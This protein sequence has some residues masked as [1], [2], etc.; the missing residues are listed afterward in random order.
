MQLKFFSNNGCIFT[1][2]QIHRKTNAFEEKRGEKGEEKIS[3]SVCWT[4]RI[5]GR[6][7]EA[8]DGVL[9]WGISDTSP[10]HI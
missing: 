1:S 10:K 8:K 5:M 6:Y 4:P 3:P 9:C 7:L 2:T